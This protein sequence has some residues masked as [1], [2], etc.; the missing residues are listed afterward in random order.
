MNKL[1][2]NWSEDRK[3]TV[4]R[5][6]LQVVRCLGVRIPTE[7]YQILKI[8]AEQHDLSLNVMIQKILDEALNAR[9]AQKNRQQ[10]TSNQ[11]PP[12]EEW[13]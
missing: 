5:G 7:L 9:N 8:T 1:N 2:S 12:D 10:Q 4:R 13:F 3:K 6:S 11:V